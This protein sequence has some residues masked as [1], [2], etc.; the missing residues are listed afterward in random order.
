VFDSRNNF[1]KNCAML[2]L[3]HT[4]AIVICNAISVT[5]EIAKSLTW[6]RPLL[7]TLYIRNWIGIYAFIIFVFYFEGTG[8]WIWTCISYLEFG[9]SISYVTLEFEYILCMMFVFFPWFIIPYI[10]NL[11]WLCLLGKQRTLSKV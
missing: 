2:W 9:V 4:M 7:K 11:V 1:N 6:P 5:S 8:W 3:I 10:E